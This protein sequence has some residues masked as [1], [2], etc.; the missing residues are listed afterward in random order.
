MNEVFSKGYR[1]PEEEY[2]GCW[3]VCDKCDY[4]NNV[5]G[6]DYCGGC[7]KRIK[8]VGEATYDWKKDEYIKKD[9]NHEE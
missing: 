2:W 7:G 4:A 1:L 6:A 9:F 8:V 3:I 5:W